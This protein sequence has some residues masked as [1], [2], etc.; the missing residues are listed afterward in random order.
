MT[1]GNVTVVLS[2]LS[3]SLSVQAPVLRGDGVATPTLLQLIASIQSPFVGG[4][5]VNTPARL[6][7]LNI[8]QG[9]VNLRK[10]AM[11]IKKPLLVGPGE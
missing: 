3:M 11:D 1:G 7:Q 10:V 6:H 5:G 4:G 8:F 9:R 2:A